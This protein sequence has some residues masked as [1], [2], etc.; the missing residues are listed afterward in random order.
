MKVEK[1][2]WN[3]VVLGILSPERPNM[4][5]NFYISLI[6]LFIPFSAFTQSDSSITRI[7]RTN[8]S[9][10]TALYYN[11]NVYAI[12][13]SGQVVI[14]NLSK[15]DTIRFPKN[16]TASYKF[17]CV[18]KDQINAV[19]FGT[20]KG[21]IFKYDPETGGW[22]LYKKLKY[23][24]HHMFFNSDNHPLVIVPYAVYDPITKRNWTEFENH[25]DGLIH[26]KRVLGLFS[27]RVY[28]YFQ[29]PQY[30]FLDSQ[31]R[32]WMTASFG[33]FGGD[34]QIFDAKNFRI[35][36]N[37][38]DSISPGLLHPKSVLEG[39][40]QNIF[41]TSGLQ[42][43]S[44]SGDIYRMNPDGSTTKV[45]HSSGPR[46]IDRK[47]KKVMDE[48]GL[49]V[50]PGAY[51][52]QDDCIYFATSRGIHKIKPNQNKSETAELVVDPALRWGS[53]PLAIGVAM[54]IKRM[55]FLPDGKLL[56]LTAMDGIG[57][58]DQGKIILLH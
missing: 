6:L 32:L 17:L 41:I 43:F 56:F 20:D 31:D 34:M 26:K 53:E 4:R 24:V 28:K 5:S 58:L 18:A 15:L 42:H 13:E 8:S 45:F 48:G 47:T 21:H 51:N 39:R 30:T 29:M 3:F 25:T 57:L 50:G 10:Q 23:S 37:K 16:D 7:E 12:S 40:G 52:K 44:N 11:D 46:V 33:E 9:Y 49:F 2:L 55:E 54:N 1:T 27:K 19:Y 14:W 22:S 38:F 36:D 35:V